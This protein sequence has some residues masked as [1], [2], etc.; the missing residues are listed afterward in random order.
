MSVLLDMEQNSNS[1]EIEAGRLDQ[2]PRLIDYC[3]KYTMGSLW[4]DEKVKPLYSQ[5]KRLKKIANYQAKQKR[6]RKGEDMPHPTVV[7]RVRSN[8]TNIVSTGSV[9]SDSEAKT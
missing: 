3:K 7:K 1:Q 8:D 5:Y 6:K 2:V 9:H 4:Y